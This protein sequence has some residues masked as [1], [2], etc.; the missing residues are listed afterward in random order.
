M[1]AFGQHSVE[2]VVVGD[3]PLNDRSSALVAAAGEA[4][5]NAAKHSRATKVSVFAEVRDDAAAKYAAYQQLFAEKGGCLVPDAIPRH[6]RAV[7]G[8]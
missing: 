4:A 5:T 2:V 3:M 8:F 7:T 1:I 6:E